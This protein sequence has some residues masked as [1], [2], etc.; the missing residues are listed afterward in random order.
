[1][2]I[3]VVLGLGAYWMYVSLYVFMSWLK[4]GQP[5]QKD[6]QC[7]ETYKKQFADLCD[8][9]FWDMVDFVLKVHRKLTKIN[10]QK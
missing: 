2:C 3:C 10:D 4:Y 7:S 5:V 6:A 1:M 9:I 8:F